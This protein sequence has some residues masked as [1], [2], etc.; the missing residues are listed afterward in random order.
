ME[1]I[2]K[3]GELYRLDFADGKSYIGACLCSAKSRFL[4]HKRSALQGSISHVHSAWRKLGTPTLV[5][6]KRNVDEKYL[7]KLEKETIHKFNTIVPYGYNGH[8]GTD[9][10]PGMRGKPGALLGK[11]FS[12]EH[13]QKIGLATKGRKLS[14]ETRSK[15]SIAKTGIQSPFLGK[16]RNFT[17]EQFERIR[18]AHL[19]FKHTE[20]SKEKMSRAR[21]GNKNSFYGKTHTAETKQKIAEANRRRHWSLESREKL[22]RAMYRR[23]HKEESVL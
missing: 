4:V 15:I 12:K 18:L 14:V 1:P 19:G 9:K 10:P 3:T 2:H 11:M 8:K 7:W 5:V 20:K 16:K 23:Y 17:A 21:K 13:R 6:L 22:R